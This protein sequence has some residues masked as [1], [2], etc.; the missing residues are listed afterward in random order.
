MKIVK[1]NLLRLAE[2]GEFDIIVQGC[3]CFCTM[4]SGLAKQIKDQY[5]EAYAADLK[6]EKGSWN[7]L[8]D[9]SLFR[10]KRFTIINAYTQFGFNKPGECK[11]VFDYNAFAIILEKLERTF[12]SSSFGFPLIGCGLAGGNK[13]R[14]LDM[15]KDFNQKIEADGGSV[16]I[17]EYA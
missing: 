13:E 5:P 8:G 4:N 10:G 2:A 15:L 7:K 11:D 3:N 16:T 1:G 17:V 12:G 9:Y 6:T 14:I